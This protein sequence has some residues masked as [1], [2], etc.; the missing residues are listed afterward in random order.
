V[1][2]RQKVVGVK[3]G[4]RKKSLV[5]VIV[6]GNGPALLSRDWLMHIQINWAEISM[7]QS[8]SKLN[9]LMEEC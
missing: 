7:V 6:K 4:H 2:Y 8:T 1:P 3:Y 9:Q 5:I